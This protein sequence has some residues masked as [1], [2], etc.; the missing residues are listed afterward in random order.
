MNAASTLKE[1]VPLP[2][3]HVQALIHPRDLPQARPAFQRA[4]T[5]GLLTHP[6]IY[7]AAASTLLRLTD[8]VGLALLAPLSL[9]ILA[10]LAWRYHLREA[11][12]YIPKRRQDRHRLAAPGEAVIEGVLLGAAFL[13]T[14]MNAL[15]WAGAD[16]L[17]TGVAAFSVGS[18]LAMTALVLLQSLR[19]F[20]LMKAQALSFLLRAIPIAS[21]LIVACGLAL[22]TFQ[23]WP[24]ALPETLYGAGMML[25]FGAGW[26][27][28][29]RR[30][31]R[32]Q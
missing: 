14:A 20:M 5:L 7:A 13:I 26:W 2:D 18:L 9:P 21:A 22:R 28:R 16:R 4:W 12:A 29:G 25:L 11:W 30:Q 3:E 19:D 31:E 32:G 10:H 24:D 17:P 8:Q 6:A 1:I 23:P 27:L 15:A